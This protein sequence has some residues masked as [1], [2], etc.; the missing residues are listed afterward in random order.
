MSDKSPKSAPFRSLSVKFFRFTSMLVIWIVAVILA[1]D[2]NQGHF[3]PAKG[4]FLCAFVL[5]VA[6]AIARFTIGL[7]IKPIRVLQLGMEE[8]GRGNLKPIKFSPTGDE[9]EY[10]ANSY[11]S[12]IQKLCETQKHLAEHQERLEEMVKQRTHALEEAMKSAV[13]ASGAKSEFLANMSH[14]LRTPMNGMLGMIELAL[15]SP[16]SPEQQEQLE[17]AQRCSFSLLSLVND[18]L[19]LSKIESGKMALEKIDFELVGHLEDI[20]KG[21]ES[22]AREKG[23]LLQWNL[24]PSLP[25][26]VSGDPLRLRQIVNNLVSN[27]IKFT[28]EGAIE[29]QVSAFK[30]AD[31]SKW[32]VE[33]HVIDTG[34]GIP[35]DRIGSIF[36]KFTQADNTISRRYGGTGLGLAIT[37]K[38]V[39]LHKGTITVESELDLGSKFSVVLEYGIKNPVVV[40]EEPVVA[41]PSADPAPV[42]DKVKTVGSVLV[43]EDNVVNQKIVMAVLKK[44]GYEIELACNGEEA[45]AKLEQR[46]FAV[47]LMDVQ[48]PVMDG[49]ET[50]RRMRADDRWKDIPVIAMTAH[51]MTGDKEKCLAAGMNAYISKPVHSAHLTATIEA[52]TSRP[53]KA[54]APAQANQSD[55]MK[56]FIEE[57]NEGLVRLR[58]AVEKA[59]LASLQ[60][61]V[62]LLR[63]A[64]EAIDATGV[65]E[66]AK[67]VQKAAISKNADEVTH[68]L[69]LLEGEITR[70]NQQTIVTSYI[71]QPS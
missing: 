70:L 3:S 15:E 37:K 57:A 55:W 29:V 65:I 12:M 27:S 35:R 45:L 67:R 40:P 54:K 64:A 50:T 18:V 31:A 22:K 13:H 24:A 38:L 69:L 30:S 4:L 47:V 56:P 62:S 42:L 2:I 11:N 51:A 7:L 44:R 60:V 61:Q 17:T 5:L 33:L 28:E 26:E 49:L 10:L 58:K 20:L 36:E 19:D 68:S 52:Y 1:Y 41:A 25:A 59:D 34:T 6:W 9:I 16:S 14:E 23:V 43:V 32:N 21:H 71:P 48:M 39:E 53:A 46:S 8:V 63:E 66:C